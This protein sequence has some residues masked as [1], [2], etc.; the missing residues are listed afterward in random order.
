M[1]K[2]KG[3]N[4]KKLAIKLEKMGDLINYEGPILSHFV[5][6]HNEDF[7]FY[8]V[9]NDEKYNRWLVYKTNSDLL[10]QFFNQQIN[11]QDLIRTAVD[12]FVYIID[13][14]DNLDYEN[15]IIA[16]IEKIPATYLPSTASYYDSDNYEEYATQLKIY[17]NVYLAR[18][19]KF[20]ASAK[21]PM[22]SIA[23]ESDAPIYKKPNG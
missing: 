4:I 7:L 16:P 10:N 1:E 5:S 20:K 9:E 22:L 3:I 12:G 21:P 19:V 18:M 11:H 13:I 2:I 23:M 15:I 17:L 6:E 8:W 14:N